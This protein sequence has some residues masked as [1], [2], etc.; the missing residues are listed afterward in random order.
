MQLVYLAYFTM[1]S[2][3]VPLT[4]ELILILYLTGLKIFLEIYSPRRGKAVRHEDTTATDGHEILGLR[5][6]DSAS[7]DSHEAREKMAEAN[8]PDRHYVPEDR[9]DSGAA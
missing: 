2:V 7:T 1:W 4:G 9:N 6:E 5:G 3:F 8:A